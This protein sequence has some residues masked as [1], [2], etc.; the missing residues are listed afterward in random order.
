[1]LFS[2]GWDLDSLCYPVTTFSL[3]LMSALAFVQLT[4]IP[5]YVKGMK[6]AVCVGLN[7]K[8]KRMICAS[9]KRQGVTMYPHETKTIVT[10]SQITV[11]LV[12]LCIALLHSNVTVVYIVAYGFK[13]DI[14]GSSYLDPL[15]LAIG[16]EVRL[17]I[18]QNMKTTSIPL[19]NC[20]KGV[21]GKVYPMF[22]GLNGKNGSVCLDVNRGFTNITL[23]GLKALHIND[24]IPKPIV[25]IRKKL[26]K[27]ENV[28]TNLNRMREELTGYEFCFVG[29][30]NIEDAHQLVND[31]VVEDNIPFGIMFTKITTKQYMKNLISVLNQLR[32]GLSHGESGVQ[33]SRGLQKT[34]YTE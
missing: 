12:N 29:N 25:G 1:M 34:R 10:I 8:E 30:M 13:A 27:I 33:A 22:F 2:T 3:M 16:Y 4:N 7:Q 19:F 17:D 18:G 31:Y 28:I 5:Q 14:N 23:F 21:K 11:S 20:Q 32:E 24:D 6:G 9:L 26:Y 15:R